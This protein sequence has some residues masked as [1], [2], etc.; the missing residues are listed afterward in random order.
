MAEDQDPAQKTEEPT[1]K[2]VEDSRRKGQ[3]ATSRE[4][5]HWFMIL[6][7]SLLVIMLAPGM[8]GRIKDTMVK[9]IASPHDV[10]L[11][12]GTVHAIAVGLIGDLGSIL[13]VPAAILM[14]LAVFGGLVQNG[15]IFAPELIK[16]KLEKISLLKG[17]KRL[18]SGRS[19]MEFTKGVLKLAIVATVATMVVVPEFDRLTQLPGYHISQLL[20]F[21]WEL[22]GRVLIAVLAVMTVVAGIDFLYQKFE[23]NKKQRMSRQEIKDEL[24]QTEGDPMIR[25]RLRQIRMERARQRMMSAVPNAAVVIT[26]PTHYAVALKYE[27]EDMEAPVLVAKGADKMA[28]RI[29]DVAEEN[30]VPIVENAPLAR[31]LYAGVEIDQEIPPEHYRVVAE[32]IGYV[33]RLSGR[34]GGPRS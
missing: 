3:V 16:P 12:P 34:H 22:S 9:F 26:N 5:N 23:H 10:T 1:Q 18:F 11:D 8:F 20:A 31:A 2:R 27:H 14:A 33:M 30:E 29:R 32:I 15:P 7:A 28:E 21:L 6:G 24:K 17:V 4:V 13:A 19:L 25:A